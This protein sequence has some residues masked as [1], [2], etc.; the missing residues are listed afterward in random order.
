MNYVFIGKIVNTHGIKG[1]I[2]IISNFERKNMVFKVGNKIYIGNGKC[3]EVINSYRVHKDYDMV[4][5]NGYDNINEVLKYKGCNVYFNRDDLKLGDDDYL[6]EDLV[7]L[8][9]VDG[10]KI[11][12]KASNFVYNSS[13]VLLEV[14]GEKKFYI[15]LVDDFVVKVDLKNRKIIVKNSEGLLL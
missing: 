5:L 8:D 15:P 12:G 11:V 13:N 4:T 3:E 6:L 10:E 14:M 2:R 9:V 7:G 1:E